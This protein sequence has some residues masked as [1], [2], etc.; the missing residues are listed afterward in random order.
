VEIVDAQIHPPIPLSPWTPNIPEDLRLV[1]ALEMSVVAMESVGVDAAVVYSSRQFCDLAASRYPSMFVGVLDLHSPSEL[2][3]GPDSFVAKVAEQVN[4]VGLRLLPGFPYSGENL[5]LLTEGRWE[6]LFVAA[7]KQ[8]IPVVLFI[9]GNLALVEPIARRHSR[10]R[11][12]V[13]HVGMPAPPLYKLSDSIFDTLP[14]LLN[15]AKFDNVAVKLSGA[16]SLSSDVYPFLDL[17]PRLH[18]II[19]RFTPERI[20]WGSDFTR[21]TG[22]TLHPRR[23]GGRSNYAELLNFVL[24][25]DE[26][27]HADKANILGKATRHWFRWTAAG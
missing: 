10:L 22:R 19:G 27:S 8:E 9:P 20:L 1:A 13:D 26:L 16:P 24:Y 21:V 5:V 18:Q 25:T 3:D 4:L 15:L 11:L 14:D 2:V 17:W 12:I 23:E 6:P 7:E